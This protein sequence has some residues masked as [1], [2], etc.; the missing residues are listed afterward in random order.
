MT[1]LN[2]ELFSISIDADLKVSYHNYAT[3]QSRF[4]LL[5]FTET[6]FEVK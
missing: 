5:E 2:L 3:V 6:K 1:K 4:I